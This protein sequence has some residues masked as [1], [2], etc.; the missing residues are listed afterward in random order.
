M[1]AALCTCVG[2]STCKEAKCTVTGLR[3][4]WGAHSQQ[5]CPADKEPCGAVC[6]VLCACLSV[7]QP[8]PKLPVPSWQLGS[9]VGLDEFKRVTDTYY[10][11]LEPARKLRTQTLPAQVRTVGLGY[12]D[13]LGWSATS[14][15]CATM[16][17]WSR[18]LSVAEGSVGTPLQGPVGTTRPHLLH[19]SCTSQLAESLPCACCWSSSFSPPPPHTHPL[20]SLGD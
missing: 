13:Q 4:G 18:H 3:L 9:S 12:R 16:L 14:A 10:K 1:L 5:Q 7:P 2:S 11:A 6:A 15:G 19:A 8:F 17:A 20:V